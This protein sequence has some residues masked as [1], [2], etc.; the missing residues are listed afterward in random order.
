MGNA[1]SSEYQVLE[2]N[3]TQNEA[4][5]WNSS[6]KRLDYLNSETFVIIGSFSKKEVICKNKVLFHQI[7]QITGI[8]PPCIEDFSS[9]PLYEEDNKTREACNDKKEIDDDMYMKYIISCVDYLNSFCSRIV[10]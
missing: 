7:K 1:R 3:L 5:I 9:P 2:R 6:M 10:D 8:E 4:R